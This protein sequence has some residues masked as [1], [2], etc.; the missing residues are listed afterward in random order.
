MFKI[1]E[2]V[3]AAGAKLIRPG[4]EMSVKGISTDSRKILKGQAFVAIKGGNFNGHDFIGIAIK[5]GASCI[6]KEPYF[7][8]KKYAGD[9]IAFLEVKDTVSAYGNIAS[10]WRRKFDI[11]LIAVTGSNGKTT[12]KEMVAWVLS[13][14]YNILKNEG[15]QNNHIGLPKALLRL[16][17]DHQAAV[18]EL[19]TNHRKEIEYLA[20]ISLPNIGIITNIGPAHLGNFGGLKDVFRE[21]YS[22]I[23]NLQQPYLAVLNRDDPFLKNRVFRP[24]KH[25]FCLGFSVKNKSDFYVSRAKVSAKELVFWVNAKHAF[26][27]K[28]VAYHNL[29]CA[30]P[31]ISLGRIFGMGYK[32]I[33]QR[34]SDFKF[35][36]GRFNLVKKNRISFIDDTYNANPAS[37]EKALDALEC[38]RSKGRKIFVMGDMLE[39]GEKS[40]LFHSQALKKAAAFCDM[41][42]TVGRLSKA[43]V[44]DAKICSTGNSKIFCCDT[45]S[46]ARRLL[47]DGIR[48]QGEDIV[49]VKGSR[50]MKMEE[51]LK[52]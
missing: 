22:L 43:A 19:G 2:L 23:N 37:L 30:L 44:E 49:L 1:D 8:D 48:P 13:A 36:A 26:R 40:R 50:A 47:K 34:L 29:Y 7:D 51:V 32:A 20:R 27:L 21:K 35:P 12:V 10:Y 42:I 15:T 9:K 33:A 52:S 24:D 28:T 38:I 39:L 17:K 41:L 14:Q 31:A 16:K 6:I 46:Q 5:K 11:P 4:R 3:K 25:P 45:S 18:L